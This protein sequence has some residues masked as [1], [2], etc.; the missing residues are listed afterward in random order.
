[1]VAII[2]A[3]SCTGTEVVHSPTVSESSVP[4]VPEQPNGLTR[5]LALDAQEHQTYLVEALDPPTHTFEVRLVVKPSARLSL[6]FL[7]PY[8]QRLDLV[9]SS[10]TDEGCVAETDRIVCLEGFPALEAQRGGEWTLHVRNASGRPTAAEIT[11]TFTR[12]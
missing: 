6:W 10:T 8:G 3:A 2:A 5:T 12:V 9:R 1:M 4:G 11:V 7:T